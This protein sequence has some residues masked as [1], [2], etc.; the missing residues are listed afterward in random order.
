MSAALWNLLSPLTTASVRPFLKVPQDPQLQRF[1]L[2]VWSPHP[3]T[4]AL[5]AKAQ[6]PN[7]ESETL[8]TGPNNLHFRKRSR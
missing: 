7:S 8:G 4:P 1:A 5:P 2:K 6:T 3:A